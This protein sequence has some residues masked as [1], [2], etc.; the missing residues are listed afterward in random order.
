MEA[1]R[2]GDRIGLFEL[3]AP[4]GSGSAGTVFRAVH[5]QSKA[6]VALKLVHESRAAFFKR[7]YLELDTLRSIRHENVVRVYAAGRHGPWAYLAMEFVPGVP[8]RTWVD[9]ASPN[10]RVDR[11]LRVGAQMATGLAAVHDAGVVH[12]DLKPE[13]AIVMG[14]GTVKLLDFG[15]AR[16]LDG[17]DA[18]THVAG[19][20]RYMAPEQ[21]AG[22]EIDRRADLF[23]LG[24]LLFEM[25]AGRP[26]HRAA[27][28]AHLILAQCTQRAVPIASLAPGLPRSA[29]LI[30]DHLLSTA[31]ADR[32]RSAHEVVLQLTK[33]L[34]EQMVPIEE[35]AAVLTSRFVERKPIVTS[36]LKRSLSREG[37]VIVIQGPPGIGLSRLLQELRGDFVVRGGR[38]ALV[39]GGPD[40]LLDVLDSIAGPLV[41]AETRDALL[42]EDRAL[43]LDSFPEL[44]RKGE[45]GAEA[46][47]W[48]RVRLATARVLR[49][50]AED[51]RPL[52]IAVDDAEK[53][54]PA[55]LRCLVGHGVLVLASH[56]PERLEIVGD[57]MEVP[58]LSPGAMAEMARSI[59]G[60]GGATLAWEENELLAGNPKELARRAHQWALA[61]WPLRTATEDPNMVGVDWE[62]AIDRLERDLADEHPIEILARLDDELPEPPSALARWRMEALA[63]WAH[64]LAGRD[65]ESLVHAT[66]AAE[67]A[68]GD[69]GRIWARLLGARCALRRGHYGACLEEAAFSW[70]QAQA[71]GDIDLALQ[72]SAHEVETLLKLGRIYEAQL[73]LERAAAQL[74]HAR[75]E[76][77]L[78]IEWIGVRVA[79]VLCGWNEALMRIA[80]VRNLVQSTPRPRIEAG[81]YIE[82]GRVELRRGQV[83]RART[84]LAHASSLLERLGDAQNELRAAATL[85]HCHLMEGNLA[86]ARSCFERCLGLA[87]RTASRAGLAMALGVGLRLARLSADA[88]LTMELLD[89]VAQLPPNW[90]DEPAAALVHSER[91]LALV[92]L[93]DTDGA[94][95]AHQAA[96]A[97]D[98]EDPHDNLLVRLHELVLRDALGEAV[99]P[100]EV[101]E[102]AVDA[103]T[104]GLGHI[105]RMA[106]GLALRRGASVDVAALVA[107]SKRA[108]D[109]L[110]AFW[111]GA[112]VLPEIRADAVARGFQSLVARA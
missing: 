40:I 85:A 16:F 24:V 66:R 73:V 25:I 42:G 43:L 44:R 72:W 59:I 89:R 28:T 51:S 87:E 14:D 92:L 13:N 11:I 80:E 29:A 98:V 27:D 26:P 109:L 64:H 97:I 8:V 100:G 36:L 102:I 81:M 70:H 30:I 3:V 6:D 21:L 32:P 82:E 52:L 39:K 46:R 74:P 4:I 22:A 37:G 58:P 108:G 88:D 67:L 17:T 91:S 60:D 61:E 45:K 65:K 63:S 106:K 105:E 31:P 103:Q 68:P 20:I 76:G 38:P 110:A 78:A 1:P 34:G 5:T 10:E 86:A 101:L 62:S 93:G 7:V 15:T 71:L 33:A 69:R 19:T 79:I 111:S 48:Q 2:P 55:D 47:P 95:A 50:A 53:A 96:Q 107:E 49:R 77:R 9:A 99:A 90:A 84:L 83:S 57:T 104:I 41:A 75:L 35:R 12:R 94:K 112:S 18:D 56:L 23:S 54:H